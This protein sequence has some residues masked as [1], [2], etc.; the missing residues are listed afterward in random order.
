MAHDATDGIAAGCDYILELLQVVALKAPQV[1]VARLTLRS[2]KHATSWFRQWADRNL[3]RQAP[4]NKSAPQDHSR[5]TGVFS[6]FIT[7][8]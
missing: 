3:K 6:E 8:L 7:C 1:Q 5:L 2:D 4:P